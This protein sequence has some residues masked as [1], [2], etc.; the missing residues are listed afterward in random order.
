MGVTLSPG[1]SIFWH[2]PLFGVVGPGTVME[3][4]ELSVLVLHP[5]TQEPG[6]IER[7]W[8]TQ[9]ETVTKEDEWSQT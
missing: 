6:R 9:V 5:L 4:S 8:I 2:S 7:G 1:D 3:I